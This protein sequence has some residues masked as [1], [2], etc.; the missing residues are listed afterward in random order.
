VRRLVEGLE[1][2]RIG[3]PLSPDTDYGPLSERVCN[4]A[5]GF[6]SRA[7]AEGAVIA[8]G[9][10]RVPGFDQGWYLQP[11]LLV[12]VN[13]SMEIAQN[14]VFGPVYCVI[15]YDTIDQAIEIANES[16]FGLAGSVFTTDEE[17]ALYVAHRVDAGSFQINA[18]APCLVAPYGGMKQSGYGRVGGVEGLLD[19]TNI[20]TIQ[21]PAK[22]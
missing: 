9:G 16:R 11:T 1:S 2:L 21:L 20:K 19:M 18:S 15:P 22:V 7:L 8:T 14:E 12:N 10:K 3:D 5:E 4:R 17:L 6:I 13:N